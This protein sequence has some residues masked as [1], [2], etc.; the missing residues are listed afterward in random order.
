MHGTTSYPLSRSPFSPSLFPLA[1]SSFS[2]THFHPLSPFPRS[3]ITRKGHFAAFARPKRAITATLPS[4]GRRR[5]FLRIKIFQIYEV[6]FS[7]ARFPSLSLSRECFFPDPSG[8][9]VSDMKMSTLTG[10]MSY[11]RKLFSYQSF[12]RII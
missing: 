2:S 4:S 3:T 11:L 5:Y 6:V 1:P 8:F 7:S 10:K 12:I 9:D